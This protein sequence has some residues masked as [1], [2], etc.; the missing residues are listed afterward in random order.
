MIDR[1]VGDSLKRR[2]FI[3]HHTSS[4][5]GLMNRQKFALSADLLGIG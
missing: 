3:S 5:F 2:A 1:Q 4:I